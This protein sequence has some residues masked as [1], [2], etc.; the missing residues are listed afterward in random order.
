M[1]CDKERIRYRKSHPKGES[2]KERVIGGK[3]DTETVIQKD[4]QI[5]RERESYGEN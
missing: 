3:S 2:D 1:Q 4:S 5:K